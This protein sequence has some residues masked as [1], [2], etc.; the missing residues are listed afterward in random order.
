MFHFTSLAKR[1]WKQSRILIR[2]TGSFHNE[3]LPEDAPYAFGAS[4]LLSSED[5]HWLQRVKYS[6]LTHCFTKPVKFVFQRTLH[7]FNTYNIQQLFLIVKLY[8]IIIV[9][10]RKYFINLFFC[11][12]SQ[13]I[14]LCNIIIT[15][16]NGIT[17]IQYYLQFIINRLY[18]TLNTRY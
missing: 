3:Y 15:I 12:I 18:S 16:P 10:I 11:F 17:I 9:F 2:V 14:N 7:C 5:F 8:F 4:R 1:Q 13:I 6:T